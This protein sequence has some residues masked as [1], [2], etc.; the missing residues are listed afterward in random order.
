MG[1]IKKHKC[2]IIISFSFAILYSLISLVNHYNFRTYALDLGLYTNAAFKYAHLQPADSGMIKEYHESILGG[3]FDLYLI[4]FSPLIY[5]FGTY[6]L[7]MVQIIA[8]IFGGIGVYSYFQIIG[9][10]SKN[11]PFYAAI[12]FYLFFGVYGAVSADYHSVVVASCI[13]PWFFISILRDKIVLSAILLFFMLISQENIALWIFF[14]CLGLMIEYRK[15]TK[16]IVHLSLLSIISVVYFVSVIY[17]VIPA[18]STHNEY[19]GFQYSFLGNTFADAIKTLFTHPIA[20][21]KTLF[22]NHTNSMHGDFVKAET[23]I[24]LLISGLPLLIKKPQYLL[25]LVPIY[26]QKFFHDHYSMW[27]I[28]GQYNIEFAPIMAIGIFK[29]ISEFMSPK[30]RITVSVIILFCVTA[31][32]IRT[33]DNTFFMTDKSRIRFYTKKHY[34]R[35][36]DVKTVHQHL[37]KIPKDAKVSAQSPF[38]PHLSLRK[39]IYQFPILK[40]AEYIVYSRKEGTYPMSNEEFENKINELEHSEDWEILYN[41]WVTILKKN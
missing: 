15:D 38:V 24:I 23:H 21:I 29:S 10:K 33:M 1:L 19:S 32:T 13:A 5:L 41:D 34:Q 40:N 25:M 35:D 4:F 17:Y 37:S 20:S 14:I 16:K 26:F 2:I 6:S 31:S 18:F 30:L 28:G 7:L 12:Y 27:G 8:L 11:T 9:S 22:I 39:N 36:Y 3:H